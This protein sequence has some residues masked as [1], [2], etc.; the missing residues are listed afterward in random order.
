MDISE[1]EFGN[2]TGKVWTGRR[3][4]CARRPGDFGRPFGMGLGPLVEVVP[5]ALA[6]CE[7]VF[8]PGYGR[9][10][11]EP[12]SSEPAALEQP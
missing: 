10:R 2:I 1:R 5:T 3:G 4:D 9:V 6:V 8:G 7:G 12:A 11:R